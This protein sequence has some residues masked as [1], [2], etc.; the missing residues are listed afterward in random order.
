MLVEVIKIEKEIYKKLSMRA[1]AREFFNDLDK[2]F[3]DVVIDFDNVEFISRSFAQEYVYQK[4]NMDINLTERNMTD[5][6]ES[7]INIVE[8]D[9]VETFG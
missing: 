5:F 3:T 9:Y 2:S 8:K 6:V 1:S 7:M 4:H